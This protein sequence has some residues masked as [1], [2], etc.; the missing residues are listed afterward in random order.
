MSTTVAVNTGSQG[1]SERALRTLRA[2]G[3]TIPDNLPTEESEDL[4]EYDSGTQSLSAVTQ[5]GGLVP[6]EILRGDIRNRHPDMPVY[7]VIPQESQLL[8]D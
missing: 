2:A 7:P 5:L 8:W 1:D 4:P 6:L 3:Y